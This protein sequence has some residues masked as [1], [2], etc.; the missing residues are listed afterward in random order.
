M[1]MNIIVSQWRTSPLGNDLVNIKNT[2]RSSIDQ[3]RNIKK[4]MDNM[5]EG[6]G[7]QE[8]D[9]IELEVRF[10]IQ[11]SPTPGEYGMALYNLVAGAITHLDARDDYAAIGM[12]NL[13]DWLIAN[14]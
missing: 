5:I 11:N 1:P 6:T 12:Q 9:Y 13:L 10:G 7:S 8:S 4:T 2:L 14:A 3:L